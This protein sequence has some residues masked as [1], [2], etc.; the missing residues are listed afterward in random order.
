MAVKYDA[1]LDI[2]RRVAD[3]VRR[4][5]LRAILG[6]DE[7]L[8]KVFDQVAEGIRTD[9]RITGYTVA[10]VR[11]V[12]ERHIAGTSE[13][14]IKIVETAI[15]DAAREA[16]VL[17][18]ETFEAIFGKE[19]DSDENRPFAHRSAPMHEHLIRLVSESAEKP[20]STD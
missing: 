9:L 18:K 16:R 6:H 7:A 17:D 3:L 10:Q 1:A 14:R 15:R 13:E 12:L 20:P 11:E 2:S 5:A 19:A 4:R 8:S